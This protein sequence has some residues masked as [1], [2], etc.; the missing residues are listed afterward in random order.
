M[1]PTKRNTLACSDLGGG[2]KYLPKLG[3]C[4]HPLTFYNRSHNK[5]SKLLFCYEYYPTVQDLGQ[6]PCPNL[7]ESVF[8]PNAGAPPAREGSSNWNQC[9][10]MVAAAVLE[11]IQNI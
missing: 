3:S 7:L 5:G 9:S 6:Y 8:L 4:P 10:L 2:P 11:T 1:G